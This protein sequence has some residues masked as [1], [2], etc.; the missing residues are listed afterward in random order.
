MKRKKKIRYSK[1]TI[2][3]GKY[4]GIRYSLEKPVYEGDSNCCVYSVENFVER[5]KLLDFLEL[6]NAARH[7][8]EQILLRKVETQR[9]TIADLTRRIEELEEWARSLRGF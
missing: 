9:T 3:I 8:D 7:T 2:F 1:G 5:F 6:Y 4:D